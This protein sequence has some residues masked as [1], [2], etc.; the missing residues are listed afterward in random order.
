MDVGLLRNDEPGIQIC[1]QPPYVDY[2]GKVFCVYGSWWKGT[3]EI[4]AKTE[5]KMKLTEF[6]AERS[7]ETKPKDKALRLSCC[8]IKK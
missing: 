4:D 8:L 5:F 7:V 3:T 2:T 6:S 1:C